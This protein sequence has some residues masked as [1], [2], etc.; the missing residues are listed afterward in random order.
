MVT[1]GFI[2]TSKDSQKPRINSVRKKM[3]VAL[4]KTSEKLVLGSCN[5]AGGVDLLLLLNARLACTRGACTAGRML[6]RRLAEGGSPR[7]NTRVRSCDAMPLWEVKRKFVDLSRRAQDHI[8]AI[9]LA[10]TQTNLDLESRR[11]IQA[12]LP[13]NT[14]NAPNRCKAKAGMR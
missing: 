14:K 7:C 12:I 8:D 5:G 6:D 3:F 10:Q 13:K 9:A 4:S 11:H 1:F 2:D